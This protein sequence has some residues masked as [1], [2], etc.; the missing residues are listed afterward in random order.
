V[1]SVY[2]LVSRRCHPI[3]SIARAAIDVRDYEGS[4]SCEAS[5]H[6]PGLS[7]SCVGPSPRSTANHVMSPAHRFGRH[8]SVRGVFQTSPS[9]CRLVEPSR[10]IAFVILRTAG[11]LPVASHPTSR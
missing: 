10:R 2:R 5:P 11:S 7:T 1:F 9:L 8:S 4:D 3:D 6:L